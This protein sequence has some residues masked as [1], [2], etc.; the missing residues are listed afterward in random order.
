MAGCVAQLHEANQR[1]EEEVELLHNVTSHR[2]V[3]SCGVVLGTVA[4]LS[5]LKLQCAALVPYGWKRKR[6]DRGFCPV[7]CFYK[8]DL[9]AMA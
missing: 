2:L 1:V 4:A 5:V 3:G 6:M 7:Q 8:R 9:C